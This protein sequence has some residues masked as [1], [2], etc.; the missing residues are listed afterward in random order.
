M[1]KSYCRMHCSMIF[2]KLLM[3]VDYLQVHLL[4]WMCVALALLLRELDLS[5][6]AG[7][8]MSSTLVDHF[9]KH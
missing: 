9:L 1:L 5:R 2:A 6:R 3:Q 8:Q 7:L 4:A